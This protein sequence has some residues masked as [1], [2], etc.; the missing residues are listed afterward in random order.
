MKTNVDSF[1]EIVFESRNKE[2]GAF[3][4]RK[5]YPKRGSIALGISL[6]ILFIAVGVPLIASILKEQ[7]NR[8][9]LEKQTQI[10]LENQ[11]KVVRNEVK[12]PPPPPPPPA[13][14]EVRFTAPVIVDSVP[15]DEI[16]ADASDIGA[17]ANSGKVDTTTAITIIEDVKV[18]EVV[19]APM[20]IFQI[21][22]KP[23]FPGGDVAL[24]TYLAK[25]TV[26]P[27]MAQEIDLQ[28]TVYIKFV[29]LKSG[30]IGDVIIL[31]S[32]DKLLDDEAVRVVRSL[33]DWTPGKFNGNAVS[34]WFIVP[35][36]F[37]L[38]N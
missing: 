30:K 26:Y 29:V 7:E 38:N 19:E 32:V 27:P 2:Y 5:K 37:K 6:I 13:V 1:D 17:N 16:M 35:I 11:K 18:E 24:N 23:E 25:N 34:V 22:E 4:L 14:K 9:Y 21:Q 10:E 3:E 33:P 28:G 31:K 15:P 8:R 20:E 12:A 36:K